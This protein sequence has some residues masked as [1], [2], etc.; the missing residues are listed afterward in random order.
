MRGY[1]IGSGWKDYQA[2]GAI[3]GIDLPAGL[4]L[5]DRLPEPVFTP[6]TKA[7]VGDH[8]AADQICHIVLART[9]GAPEGVPRRDG[10]WHSAQ[11]AESENPAGT[12]WRTK[13]NTG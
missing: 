12:T 4:Q 13:K 1:L 5:A 3:C 10:T 7:A 9:E 2:S 6:S 8:D 11:P